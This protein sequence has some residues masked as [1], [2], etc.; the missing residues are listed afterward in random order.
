MQRSLGG[1]LEELDE[2]DP[3]AIAAV[4]RLRQECIEAKE[5]LSSDTDA[6]IP[7]LLPNLQTEVRL[8]RAELEA[9]VRPALS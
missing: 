3:T 6:S 5:A 1:K 9:M 2:D 4:A 7:V 8:T